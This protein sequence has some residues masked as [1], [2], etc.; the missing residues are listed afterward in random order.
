MDFADERDDIMKLVS[1]LAGD[2]VLERIL[3]KLPDSYRD[4]ILFRCVHQLSVKET[5]SV[6]EI[7]ESLVRK[8]QQRAL[9]KLRLIIGDDMYAKQK[10]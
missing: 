3:G 7:S 6:L 4:V 8:R 2:S 1:R 9:K 5:A 10:I